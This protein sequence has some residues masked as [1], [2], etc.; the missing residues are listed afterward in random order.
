M[1]SLIEFR[2]ASFFKAFREGLQGSAP[3]VVD[4]Q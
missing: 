2:F 1:T 3:R 4:F